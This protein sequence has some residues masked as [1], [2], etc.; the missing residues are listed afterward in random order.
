MA[1]IKGLVNTI[2]LPNPHI[3]VSSN[4]VIS[5]RYVIVMRRFKKYQKA[6]DYLNSPNTVA[7]FHIKYHSKR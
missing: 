4:E 7:V 1:G 5:G 2:G 6:I 3:I